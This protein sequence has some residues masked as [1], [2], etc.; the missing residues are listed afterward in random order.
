[1]AL[2]L[3][4]RS[5]LPVPTKLREV[6]PP[7]APS[8]EC[9]IYVLDEDTSDDGETVYGSDSDDDG[10]EL[11]V[12]ALEEPRDAIPLPEEILDEVMRCTQE[13]GADHATLKTASLVCRAWSLPA[14]RVLFSQCLSVA[15]QGAVKRLREV[16][17]AQPALARAIRSF[18]VSN[19]ACAWQEGR[20]SEI[21]RRSAALL[22]QTPNV[23]ELSMLHIALSDKAR[24][25]FFGALKALPIESAHI[26]SS[27]WSTL[28]RNGLTTRTVGGAV[29]DMQEL[30]HTL[31]TWRRLK[32]L[33]LSGYSAYPRLFSPAILP[34]YA[35]PTFHLT[36]LTIIS[37]DLSGSTLPWLLGSS[38]SSLKRLNLAATTGLTKETLQHVFTLVGPTLEVLLLSLDVDDLHPASASTPLD[39]ALLLS[40]T[41]LRSFNL[42]TD[43]VFSD[44][45]LSTLVT[46]PCL[47]SIS[48]C[49]PSFS[50]DA[51]LSALE[52]LP[53][54][55]PGQ[56]ALTNLVL[57]AWESSALWT[58][59]GRWAALQACEK[60]GIALALNGL[61]K[62]DIEEEWFGEDLAGDWRFLEAEEPVRRGSRARHLWR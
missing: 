45:L 16:V 2:F 19:P 14:R 48:L 51:V 37:T 49:F 44:T 42:S 32:A 60:R 28:G 8:S 62:E 31:C 40:L 46:L 36:D 9:P 18:D 5:G 35:F 27:S 22:R 17:D 55:G 34:A 7:L 6:F 39:D 3:D 10:D 29:P 57:D 54:S 50:H 23:K 41:A 56:G 38:A 24:L 13:D 21:F 30:A 47:S 4:R 61:V 43:T 15:S 25:K 59:A 53:L 58:E 26:Y 1:M 12:D 20:V 33:T 11:F 52:S